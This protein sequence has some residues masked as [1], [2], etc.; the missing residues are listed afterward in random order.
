MIAYS[1]DAVKRISKTIFHR[2]VVPA[3][4]AAY[5]FDRKRGGKLATKFFKSF[6]WLYAM[7][8][9]PALRDRIPALDPNLSYVSTIPINKDIEG[10]EGIALPEEV[11]D[12]LIDI[13]NYRVIL[14]QCACRAIYGCEHYPRDV[15]CIFMGE[16]ARKI[17]REYGRE[18][19]KEEARAHVR[20]A[21][22]AGLVPIV[23][24]A[25]ADYELLRIPY[26][27]RLLTNCFCCE[28]CCLSRAFRR[29]PVA[30]VDGI[31]H[32][33]EGLSVEVT[34]ACVGC[35]TCEKACF[36]KAIQ[37]R[38]GR[39][40]I[41]EYCRVCGRCA[42]ACPRGAIKLRLDN[43]NAVDDVVNRI[44]GKVDLS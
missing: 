37:V 1:R 24:E 34:D 43:P 10:A 11:L 22:A 44:L 33:V 39:A 29:G 17:P 32:P 7:A 6:E 4:N 2:G 8:Y 41:D 23:G 21:I 27:G 35:G 15:G 12:R 19:T 42:A 20:R 14:Q 9:I 30:T 38:G 3:F 16:S 5:E 25:R 18:A 28:C 26:D 13:S 36:I 40:I 31:M